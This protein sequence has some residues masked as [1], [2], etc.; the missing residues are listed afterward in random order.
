MKW[1]IALGYCIVKET[2][3]F[4]G[5]ML[6]HFGSLEVFLVSNLFE[7]EV[8]FFFSNKNSKAD[9]NWLLFPGSTLT[10]RFVLKTNWLNVFMSYGVA[11]RC[12]SPCISISRAYTFND[13]GKL[14]QQ[15]TS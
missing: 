12:N 4:A 8:H 9:P 10:I 11:L 2:I 13:L 5:K 3:W 7:H 15:L 6:Q 1:L 14:G